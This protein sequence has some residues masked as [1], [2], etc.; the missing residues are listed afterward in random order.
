[1]TINQQA[2]KDWVFQRL[3]HSLQALAL[4]GDQQAQRF[5]DGVVVADELVLDFN[6]WQS[7]AIESYRIDITDPQL[8][9]LASLN[10][11]IESASGSVAEGIWQEHA[12]RSHPFWHDLRALAGRALEVFGWPLAAPPGYGHEYFLG[13]RSDK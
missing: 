3:K 12:L 13:E 4:P 6:H 8:R 5:P 11:R 9:C 7:C 10:D 1:M 2:Q